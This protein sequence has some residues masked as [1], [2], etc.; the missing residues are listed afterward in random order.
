[1]GF[2]QCVVLG[3]VSGGSFTKKQIFE[4]TV[5]SYI[6]LKNVILITTACGEAVYE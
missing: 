2:V 3:S 5:D 4:V 6:I 1:M